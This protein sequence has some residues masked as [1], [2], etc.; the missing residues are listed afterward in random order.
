MRMQGEEKPEKKMNESRDPNLVRLQ[1]KKK[2]SKI[3]VRRKI[4][5]S[6]LITTARCILD[7]K[8][9][10]EWSAQSHD[11]KKVTSGEKTRIFHKCIVSCTY[12][13]VGT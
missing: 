11:N 2:D 10:P 4:K 12:T 5:R 9:T 13:P 6:N 7:R 1:T 3:E 8:I